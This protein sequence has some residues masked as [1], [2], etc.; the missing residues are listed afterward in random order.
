MATID[1]KSSSLA[2]T[3][4]M[5]TTLNVPL[6]DNWAPYASIGLHELQFLAPSLLTGWNG[7]IDPIPCYIENQPSWKYGVGVHESTL[8]SILESIVITVKYE[9][10]SRVEIRHLVL[11][12]SSQWVI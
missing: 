8:R 5:E 6:V 12:G 4:P 3:D 11:D 9:N 10:D 2:S 1:D 7:T